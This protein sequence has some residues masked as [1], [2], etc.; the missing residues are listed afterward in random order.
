MRVLLTGCSSVLHSEATA[1]DLESM[2][3]VAGWL[4]DAGV[5]FDLALSPVLRAADPATTS[6]DLETLDA[7]AY[8]VLV[9]ACGPLHSWQVDALL[10]RLDVLVTTR[11][12]GLVLGLR[13]GIPVLAVDPVAGG[14]KVTAQASAL[15]W[16]ALLDAAAVEP[17]A[18]EHWL[19]W[20]LGDAGRERARSVAADARAAETAA[21]RRLLD[22]LR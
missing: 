18:L 2:R 17:G 19:Q 12:H 13:A 21:G 1:G 22:A 5:P 14:A 10:R 8:T 20:C 3:R 11:L 16:P 9:F 7:P 15:G 6:V 4:D